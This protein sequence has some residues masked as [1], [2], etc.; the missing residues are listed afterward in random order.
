MTKRILILAA[1]AVVAISFK[2]MKAEIPLFSS[3]GEVHR[4][5]GA[6]SVSSQPATTVAEF[7]TQAYQQLDFSAGETLQPAVFEKAVHGYLALKEANKLGDQSNILSVCDF[8]L[9]SGHRRL[10][11]IDMATK[12]VLLND[13]VAHGA[14]SGEE[15]ATDFSNNENSHQSSLGFYVTGETYQGQHGNSLRLIG[16]DK[17]FNCA[18]LVRGIVVHGASYVNKAYA[19]ANKRIGRSWGCPA[20]NDA[21]AQKV[22]GLT[23]GGSCMF[24]Y[25]GDKNYDPN[26]L[27][28]KQNGKDTANRPAVYKVC[29]DGYERFY[30]GAGPGAF[31]PAL[32]KDSAVQ[33]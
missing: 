14:G 30:C 16:L 20:V 5:S 3:E 12:K 15:M 32:T 1:A 4:A 31:P 21:I 6:N 11:I 7:A 26:G 9:S 28:G 29:Y 2:S 24:I 22:I 27:L 25:A 33:N 18:A 13:L 17:G 10:W 23:K 19:A 8:S